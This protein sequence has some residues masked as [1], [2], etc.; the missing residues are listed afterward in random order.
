MTATNILATI[1]C[2]DSDI[3]ITEPTRNYVDIHSDSARWS[4]DGFGFDI[5]S[6]IIEHDVEFSLEIISD[7]GSWTSLFSLR[8]YPANTPPVPFLL[9]NTHIFD[10]AGEDDDGLA[11]GGE[12]I[13]MPVSLFNSGTDTATNISAVLSTTDADITITENTVSYLDIL[14]DSARWSIG[15][16]AFDINEDCEEHDVLFM[17]EIASDEGDWTSYFTVHILTANQYTS[18][19]LLYNTHIYDP[20]G[21]DHDIYPEGGETIIMP[22]SVYNSGTATA[23]HVTAVLSCSDSDIII[24]ENIMTYV[25]IDSDSAKWSNGG[26]SFEIDLH[27][28]E[29]DVEFLIEMNSD[30]GSWFTPF[31]VRIYPADIPINP[32]LL[33]NTH[34]F[35]P[36]GSD[37]DGVAEG[38]ET[39][40]LPVSIFNSGNIEATNISAVLSCSDSDITISNNLVS[41]PDISTD[42]SRFGDDGFVFSI[43]PITSE[44]D[45]EF[46]INMSSDEGEWF[47][48]FLIHVYV[49]SAIPEIK[50]T[51]NIAYPNPSNGIFKLQSNTMKGIYNYRLLNVSGKEIKNGEIHFDN[52]LIPILRFDNI[53]TG[54]YFLRMDNG[55]EIRI[56]KLIIQ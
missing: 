22:I 3:T 38:G 56:Q 18:P 27:C 21:D 20:A 53:E 23:T 32:Y 49:A 42:S 1:T 45:I 19:V 12:S 6:G 2:T 17:I 48:P 43:S 9:Y 8:I 55:D 29:R 54:I 13:I 15:G 16:F 40:G 47:S 34:I 44:R 10:P 35:D 25:D 11:E 37:N 39:I 31:L 24:T 30:E 36:A 46:M 26:F 14:S 4:N 51:V 41:Y 50:S 52:K 5:A 28:I 7:E 33:Y